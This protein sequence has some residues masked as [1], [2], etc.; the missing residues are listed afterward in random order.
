MF[1]LIVLAGI[2]AQGLG[3]PL[4][5]A[6]PEGRI[7]GGE[8]IPIEGAPYQASLQYYNQH[9][10]GATIASETALITAAHCFTTV[11]PTTVRVGSAFANDPN[12]GSVHRIVSRVPHPQYDGTTY[13]NDIIILHV[14]PPI[15]IDNIKT[16]AAGLINYKVPEKTIVKV[17][18]WGR[19][20]GGS[21]APQLRFVNTVI[22]NH[23]ECQRTTGSTKKICAGEYGRDTCTGDSGGPLAIE[24]QDNNIYL[25]GVVSHGPECSVQT[26]NFVGKYTDVLSV[27]KWVVNNL[28]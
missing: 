5:D 4:E 16:V 8:A 9:H 22:L 24:D 7:Y 27:R 25:V 21:I 6:N 12:T 18:G 13:E 14:S 2:L 1:H 28:S 26:S 3:N 20:E 11:T 17:S 15:V 19:Y 10:C 23:E